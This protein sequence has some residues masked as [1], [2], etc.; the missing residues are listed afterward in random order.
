MGLRQVAVIEEWFE[1]MQPV[2]QEE[3]ETQT[4]KE[5]VS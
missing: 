2:L 1:A 4:A 3:R 5:A